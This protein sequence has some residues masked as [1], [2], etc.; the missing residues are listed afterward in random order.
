MYGRYRILSNLN[1]DGEC[2]LILYAKSEYLN[3][4]ISMCLLLVSNDHSPSCCN[5]DFEVSYSDQRFNMLTTGF[6]FAIPAMTM[7][8]ENQHFYAHQKCLMRHFLL[9]QLS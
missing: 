6:P 7:T 4:S 1:L 5:Q 9:M 3:L 8:L 2:D